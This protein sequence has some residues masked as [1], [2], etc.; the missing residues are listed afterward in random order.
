MNAIRIIEFDQIE[1]CANGYFRF[2]GYG[3]IKCF[4]WYQHLKFDHL[5]GL[6]GSVIH[7]LIL[8]S[9]SGLNM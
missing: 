8:N 5:L 1:V 6:A 2:E 3:I 7:A 9:N 4:T